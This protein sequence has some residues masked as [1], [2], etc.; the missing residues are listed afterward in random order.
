MNW[1]KRIFTR[2]RTVHQIDL[3]GIRGFIFSN[4]DHGK[5]VTVSGWNNEHWKYSEGDLA[6]LITK[7][8]AAGCHGGTYRID[9]VKHCSDPSDMYFIDCT[10]VGAQ[11]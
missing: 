9:R 5:K 7:R 6:Q 11:R 10:Y 8:T 1:L 3:D 4:A 2:N